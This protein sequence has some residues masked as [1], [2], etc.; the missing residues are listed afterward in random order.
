MAVRLLPCLSFLACVM[1]IKDAFQRHM[2]LL[3]LDPCG[4]LSP[5][6]RD[7][8]MLNQSYTFTQHCVLLSLAPAFFADASSFGK[9]GSLRDEE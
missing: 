7:G 8:D 6:D 3:P 4:T 5:V 1:R 9:H 2:R